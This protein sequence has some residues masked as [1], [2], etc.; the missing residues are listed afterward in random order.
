MADMILGSAQGAVGSL[1]S[2]LTSALNEE[3]QLLGSVRADVQFIK[4]EME[5]M[6]GF[7]LHMVEANGNDKYEDHRASA[8]MKQVAEV[9]YASQNCVDMY[10]QSLGTRTGEQGLLGFLQR[11]PRLFWT[12][13][14][15]HRIAT[16]IRELKVRAREVGE[17]QLRYG[18]TAP[19]RSYANR[20]SWHAPEDEDTKEQ[21]DARRRALVEAEPVPFE[22]FSLIQWMRNLPCV[23]DEREKTR[24]STRDLLPGQ[25]VDVIKKTKNSWRVPIQWGRIRENSWEI[26]QRLKDQETSKWS[27][28]HSRWLLED[29]ESNGDEDQFYDFDAD[30]DEEEE[31]YDFFDDNGKGSG[32]EE[33][34]TPIVIALEGDPHS[35]TSQFVK[36]AFE[37]P[38]VA[39]SC[40]LDYKAWI[41]LGPE[42]PPGP[43][44]LLQN[45]LAKLHPPVG[46]LD[47]T[48]KWNDK[49]LVEKIQL[50]L[51]GKKFLIV[52][53]DV[54]DISL[55]DCI[56]PAL[57]DGN[58]SPGSAF[59]AITR[60]RE[61]T[62]TSSFYNV[63]EMSMLHS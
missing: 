16:Q 10:V 29:L 9:A 60:S 44:R 25:M 61:V 33:K 49:Q 17:R 52:L 31:F 40:C 36:K 38:W 12:L 46:Q 47:S 6:I 15:R 20:A 19:P 55:W 58:F 7:L 42:C 23:A 1:L 24:N 3:A 4:D 48:D 11:L 41:Q 5:S 34:A 59:V 8:W 32:D 14:A 63:F 43:C 45:I 37:D 30:D 57:L 56:K 2:R 51:K 13:P 27:H 26:N 53:E 21:E 18:V 50:H 35:G 62:N 39:S 22:S 54:S 28:S